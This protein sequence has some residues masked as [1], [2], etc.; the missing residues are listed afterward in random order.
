MAY[1][2]IRC[3]LASVRPIRM[4]FYQNAD[5]M[6]P[7]DNAVYRRV[8][9]LAT[10]DFRALV[11]VHLLTEIAFSHRIVYVLDRVALRLPSL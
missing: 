9:V 4:A 5:R 6:M 1:R 11:T 10:F 8:C 3:L 2:S 7:V